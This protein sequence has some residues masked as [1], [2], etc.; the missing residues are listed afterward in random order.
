MNVLRRL[1]RWLIGRSSTEPRHEWQPTGIRYTTPRHYD[2]AKA[3]AG[4]RRSRAH[5]ETGRP[6]PKPRKVKARTPATVVPM[7]RAK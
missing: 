3:S 2:E 5:S 1:Y 7:R 4:Y 6:L